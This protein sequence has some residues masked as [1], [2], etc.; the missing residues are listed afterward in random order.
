M[1]TFT[2]LAD[3]TEALIVAALGTEADS[4]NVDAIADEAIE[5]F[6]DENGQYLFRQA[7]DTD[8]FWGIVA[9]HG[10]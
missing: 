5:S 4:H 9:K 2:T 10:L 6:N 8:T 7:V 3:A 1:E